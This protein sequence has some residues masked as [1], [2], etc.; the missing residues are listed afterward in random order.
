ME[1]HLARTLTR[2]RDP[3]SRRGLVVGLGI[4]AVV[5]TAGI[6]HASGGGDGFLT[7]P[8]ASPSGSSTPAVQ[9]SVMAS[10]PAA[11]MS[12]APAMPMNGQ[13]LAAAN[14]CMTES[15]RMTAAMDRT[16]QADMDMVRRG[17]ASSRLRFRTVGD[18]T[19]PAFNQVLGINNQGTVVG[20]SGS[21]EDA[22]HP[23]RGY[24]IRPPYRQANLR[25]LNVPNSVQT[26]DIGINRR[27]DIVG[28]SVDAQGVTS[29]FVR[30]G[31]MFSP[32]ANP[33][34][35]AKP[36]E[37]QL[38]SINDRRVAAGFYNDAAGASHPYLYDVC[39][40]TFMPVALPFPVDS[41]QATGINNSGTVTGLYVEG[42]V[43]HAFIYE[44]KRVT[45]LS[46]G[47]GSN[48]Q[49]LGINNTGD[50]AGSYVDKQG[51]THGFVWT[52]GMARTI[53]APHA[54][55][56][57][58]VNGLNDLGQLVGFYTSQDKRTIGFIAR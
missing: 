32:V 39:H 20:Y 19:V 11:A 36:A 24:A 55:G 4:V 42:K 34:G 50:V 30:M 56:S 15:A 44:G 12:P 10:A 21:G 31:G 22:Q 29:G 37:N 5:G 13:Q 17:P 27:G 54:S 7:T 6:A 52:H 35:A 53:D 1:N 46:L 9:A 23:N 47:D 40:K 33:L 41:A 28:F 57:T 49:A 43:T 38:L 48:T 18:S 45:S 25:A 8:S 14:T 26:Q 2:S 3:R 51:N 16:G 58:V